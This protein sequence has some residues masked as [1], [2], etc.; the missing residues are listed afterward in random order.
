MARLKTKTYLDNIHRIDNDSH[1]RHDKI[2][3]DKSERVDRFEPDFFTNFIKTLSQEDFI[4]Y[5]E[6]FAIKEKII[7]HYQLED[8]DVYVS[9]GID[10]I[11]KSFY[12]IADNSKKAIITT[13][14]FPMYKVYS[15]LFNMEVIEIGYKDALLLDVNE[16]I[17]SIDESVG[18]VLIANP[19]SPVG[20]IIS[21]QKMYEIAKK[22]YDFQIPLLIDEAYGEFCGQTSLSLCDEFSNIGIAKTFSKALGGA[23]VRLGYLIGSK[24][25]IKYIE[26]W[27]PMYEVNQIAI[28]YGMYMLDNI[29]LI[30]SYVA[31]TIEERNN[32]FHI[33]KN[34]NYEVIN[35][36]ANW[37][38]IHYDNIND[39][40][41]ILEKYNV[42]FKY[43][44]LPLQGNKTWLRLTIFPEISQTSYF[45]EI[46][47]LNKAKIEN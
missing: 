46:L 37:V 17:N 38:H 16:L 1:T 42:L 33:L 35:T 15:Q 11:I 34:S 32:V 44:T 21:S 28:K 40:I 20:D 4:C 3:L 22:C 39:I 5:P 26:K 29:S 41:N 27:R 31:K 13:P 2:R 47:S 24:D 7:N 9:S 6:T 18:L 14:C 45:N 36:Y 43:G 30:E 10:A 25:L 8:L 12:E 19:V 23:G